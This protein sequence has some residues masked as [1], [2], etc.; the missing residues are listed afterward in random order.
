[1]GDD[2]AVKI[3]WQQHPIKNN[4]GIFP[5]SPNFTNNIPLSLHLVDAYASL[6]KQS[7]KASNAPKH[8]YHTK[9]ST[10]VFISASTTA[11]T[12]PNHGML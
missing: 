5:S 8:K 4:A 12:T 9:T 7:I 3:R 10:V 11:G 6:V 1:M 2:D